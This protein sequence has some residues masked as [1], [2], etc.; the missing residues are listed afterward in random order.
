MDGG[1]ARR[2]ASPY[3]VQHNTEKRTHTHTSMPWAE[4][5]PTHDLSF[6]AVEDNTRSEF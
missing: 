6:Q 5:E 4:F 3:T 1:S 2:K